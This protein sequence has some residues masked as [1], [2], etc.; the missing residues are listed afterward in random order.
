M[1]NVRGR[2]LLIFIGAVLISCGQRP[3]A[4]A[5]AAQGDAITIDLTA[6]T[7]STLGWTSRTSNCSDENYFC[8]LVPGKMALA[9]P[10]ACVTATVVKPLATRAGNLKKVAPMPHLAPPS[11]SYIIDTYPRILIFYFERQGLT[12]VREL[13]HSPYEREFA[14]GDYLH[15][16][17]VRTPDNQP[18]FVCH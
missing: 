3:L 16:Y 1:S 5:R 4:I 17:V 9:F 6:Q 12:E 13:R 18:L 14:P 11:G 15:R 7:A 2:L 8:L 10:R